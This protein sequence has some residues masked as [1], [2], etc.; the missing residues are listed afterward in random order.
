MQPVTMADALEA[1]SSME[2]GQPYSYRRDD[3]K[4]RLADELARISGE[5][6]VE[7]VVIGGLAVNH[8]GY[9][10]LTADLD[11][12][13][14]RSDATALV[15]R[16]KSERGWKRYAEGFKNTLLD[17]SVDICVEGER[18]SPHSTETFPSPRE[19]QLVEVDPLPVPTLP[20]LIALKV[21]AGRARDD[22]DVVELLKR[23]RRRIASV[24]RRA[25]ERLRTDGARSRLAALVERA[26][27]ELARRRR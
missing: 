13:L 1:L 3:P 23:H 12:L 6:G 15:R 20:E 7:P 4:R 19:L 16:L 24:Q 27:E 8:H 26:R 17:V 11:V 25:A 2:E 22:A 18:T 21:M 10:R 14:A 9:M 5:L